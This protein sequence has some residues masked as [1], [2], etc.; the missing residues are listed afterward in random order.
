MLQH[1]SIK[2]Y[3]LIEELSIDFSEGLSIITGETG[4]GKSILLGALG[5]VLGNRAD[6]STLLNKEKKCVVEA[7][8]KLN[9]YELQPLFEKLD[10][11]YEPITILR[12]EI[13][14]SGKSRA[15][16]NDTPVTLNVLNELKTKL[17]DIHSQHQTLQIS[18]SQFQFQLI[19]AL[20]GNTAIVE[21]YKRGLQKWQ[22]SVS[23]LEELKTNQ[24]EANQQFDY[25]QYLFQ[26]LEEANLTLGEQE[27]LEEKLEKLNNVEDIKLNLSESLQMIVDDNLG[28]QNLLYSLQSKLSSISNFSKE[29]Q[30]LYERISSLKIEL[31]DIAIELENQNEQIEFNP[32]EI[33]TLSNRI[34]LIYNLQKKHYVSTV[35]EL[36]QIHEELSEKVAQVENGEEIIAAKEKEVL[37][38]ESTLNEVASKISAN[39]KAVL[40]KLIAQLENNISELGM[41]NG[42]FALELEASKKFLSNGKDELS[43][44]FSANKG[45]NFGELKKV[46]SGGELSRIMLSIKRVLS[47]N[48]Q[49]P[50]IIFDEIDTGVSGEI[51]NKMSEIMQLMSQ[52]MQ[53]I[54]ITHLPQIAAKGNQHFKVFK[55]EVEGK[56][57]TSLKLLSNDERIVEIAEMLSGKNISDTALTHAKEL[58]N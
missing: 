30:D 58:L 12:R 33:D 22:K 20:A 31:D 14:P 10:L 35:E 6:S 4:A 13:T 37:E 5:L 27:S 42:K 49:L 36:Q 56:T 46:A 50:T 54:T 29:Y 52:K 21:S 8:I 47:E 53:V 25:N 39:R 2:N 57:Q 19:D 18:D 15:F 44:L 45:G 51:S 43:F 1:L 55:K 16:V 7:Q 11:D 24:R 34:Q 40:P 23:E 38:I 26:E 3:A 48:S 32:N 28:A 41:P 9:N 17:V